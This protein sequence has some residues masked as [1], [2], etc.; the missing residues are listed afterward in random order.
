MTNFL[1]GWSSD[2]VT[3]AIDRRVDLVRNTA[4]ALTF[5]EAN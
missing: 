2:I 4:V 3:L 1:P 5:G